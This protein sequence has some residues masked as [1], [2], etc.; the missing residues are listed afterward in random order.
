MLL[1]M[2]T[3]AMTMRRRSG[4]SHRGMRGSHRPRRDSR[5]TPPVVPPY[6]SSVLPVSWTRNEDDATPNEIALRGPGGYCRRSS[7]EEEE[8]DEEEDEDS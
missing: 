5:A 1:A 6:T 2:M 8:E 4:D 7:W 3:M